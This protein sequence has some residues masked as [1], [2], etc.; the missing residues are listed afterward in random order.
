MSTKLEDLNEE[1]E[2]ASEYEESVYAEEKHEPLVVE[3]YDK[4][5]TQVIYKLSGF[6][7][8]KVKHPLLIL[9]LCLFFMNPAISD[10]FVHMDTSKFFINVYLSIL[11][12]LFFSI[13]REFI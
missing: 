2:Y 13:I 11:I 10:V 9:L 3:A 12:T 6:V 5:M 8:D 1:E 7:Y 4:D